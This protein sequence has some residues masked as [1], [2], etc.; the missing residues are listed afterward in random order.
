MAPPVVAVQRLVALESAAL[1]SSCS[2]GQLTINSFSDAKPEGRGTGGT[3]AVA[4][5]GPPAS[6]R[7]V[8]S[9][10]PSANGA[11]FHAEKLGALPPGPCCSGRSRSLI[12]LVNASLARAVTLSP[13]HW[14]GSFMPLEEKQG[15]NPSSRCWGIHL[16]A[17][18]AI[19]A[20][21]T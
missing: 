11:S 5:S 1:R 13:C 21:T 8:G 18:S 9:P 15:H 3:A 7:G 16:R 20:H 19:S 4:G 17:K 2:C 12:S 14:A 6:G 10:L